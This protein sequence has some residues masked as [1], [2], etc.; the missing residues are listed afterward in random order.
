MRVGVSFPHQAI[1]AD[2]VAIRDWAHASEDLGF[3]HLIVYE[4]VIGPD[5]DLHPGETFRYTNRTRWHEPLVLCGFLAAVTQRIGLQTGH[6]LLPLHETVVVAKQ[7]AEVDVLSGGRLRLGVG[8]G[9]MASEF[10]ASV[11]TSTRGAPGWTSRWTC[12]ARYGP[13]TRSRSRAASTTLMARASIHSQCSGRSRCGLA[14]ACAR[15]CAALPAMAMGGLHPAT[16]VGRPV[17]DEA[18]QLLGWLHE[19][20]QAAGRAAGGAW[21]SGCHG[22]RAANRRRVGRLGGKLAPVWCDGPPHRH[23]RDRDIAGPVAKHCSGADPGAAAPGRSAWRRLIEH[24]VLLSR[25]A[26][27]RIGISFPHQAIGPDPIGIRDWAQTA[28]QLGFDHMVVYEHVIL[29]DAVSHPGET[30]PFTNQESLHEPL[31]LCGFL[32]G[33][34]RRIGLQTG[35]LILPLRDTVILAKQAAEVDVLSGGRLRLGVGA[36]YIAFEFDA[37]GRNFH[38]RGARMDEQLALLRELWTRSAVTFRG[39]EH[40]IDGAGL[41]PL[42]VQRP[43]PLWVAGTVRASVRRAA[44]YGAGWIASGAYIDRP[45]DDEARQLLAYLHQ[46]AEAAGRRPEDSGSRAL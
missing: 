14:A 41:N 43:I 16:D 11:A 44:R 3:D 2:P 42:P 17:D 32:A 24:S 38:A 13:A 9:H 10:S 45:V 26:R 20:A 30:F 8:A 39:R 7:A 33:V 5:P 29:P 19:E 1:G 27:M 34:T 35:I 25:G 36:G 12:C 6:L 22:C 46:E 37:L 28:E 15:R 31:V 40:R 23:G 21:D 4:H 18:R